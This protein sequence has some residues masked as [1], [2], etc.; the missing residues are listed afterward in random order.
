MLTT[1]RDPELVLLL[2]PRALKSEGRQCLGPAD[3][4]LRVHQRV[5]R[6]QGGAEHLHRG[7]CCSLQSASR[8]TA[9]PGAVVT[10]HC[11][12]AR[13]SLQTA[14]VSFGRYPRFCEPSCR[15]PPVPGEGAPPAGSDSLC[16][17]KPC[18]L[19]HT[20]LLFLTAQCLKG[21]PQ[22]GGEKGAYESGARTP[23]QTVNL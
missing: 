15:H 5:P 19:K 11:A 18:F 13:W 9:V 8:G 6:S 23:G 4:P 1:P 14:E 2:P 20:V 3:S 10:S 22:P 7:Q 17:Q 21:S 12:A 16:P